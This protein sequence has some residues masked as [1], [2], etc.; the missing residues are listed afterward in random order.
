MPGK[1]NFAEALQL[2]LM[3]TNEYEVLLPWYLDFLQ[4]LTLKRYFLDIGAGDGSSLTS[5]ADKNFRLGIAIEKTDTLLSAICKNC[6]NTR[7]IGKQIEEVNDKEIRALLTNNENSDT[8][9]DLI[10]MIH[11]LYYLKEE[12]RKNLFRRLAIQVRVGGVI[13]AVLQD[14]TSDYY[15]LYHKNTPHSYNLRKTGE[16][17]QAEFANWQV[18]SEVLPGKVTCHNLETAQRIVE[19]MLCYLKFNPL[20]KRNMITKWIKDTL[21]QADISLYVANNPQRIIVCR[22]MH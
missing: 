11:F 13:L 18:T 15:S 17:F 16:W 14:E 10:Q 3:H 22:R 20:P 12:E 21:W 2:F 8:I 9:F 6:P 7:V 19:F 4:S 5:E 1:S